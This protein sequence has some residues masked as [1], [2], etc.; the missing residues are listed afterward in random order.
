MR[1]EG[2]WKAVDVLQ[3]DKHVSLLH[4]NSARD[5]GGAP[6]CCGSVMATACDSC[7]EGRSTQLTMP[8]LSADQTTCS[9]C[10]P[11]AL[12]LSH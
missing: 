10:L 7:N 6:R 1:E 9:L 3:K 8:L 4:E 12:H 5:H 2:F 11:S